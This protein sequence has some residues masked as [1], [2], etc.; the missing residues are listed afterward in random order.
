[1]HVHTDEF[2]LKA[3]FALRLTCLLLTLS[4]LLQFFF[5]E[6]LFIF[7]LF[8]SVSDRCFALLLLLLLKSVLFAHD[9][10]ETV[11]FE[12]EDPRELAQCVDF[13][14]LKR[15]EVK[16]NP[17]QVDNEDVRSLRNERSLAQIDLAIAAITLIVV[18]NLTLDL[19]LK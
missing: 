16:S 7:F 1:M 4:P 6:V 15:L 3:V 13:I 11:G 8:E 9:L 5:S 12:V 10:E 14:G 18:D 19:L 2:V 17:L